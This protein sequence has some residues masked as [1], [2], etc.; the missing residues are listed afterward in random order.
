[1]NE[2][3]LPRRRFLQGLVGLVAAPAIVRIAAM[4]PVKTWVEPPPMDYGVWMPQWSADEQRF[5]MTKVERALIHENNCVISDWQ[6]AW[7]LRPKEFLA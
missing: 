4:M 7:I 1:M 5:M 2:L 6:R 3:I